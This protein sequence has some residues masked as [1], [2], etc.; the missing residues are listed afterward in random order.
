MIN[1][2]K[3][4]K[5]LSDISKRDW[6]NK[7]LIDKKVLEIREIQDKIVQY[8]EKTKFLDNCKKCLH[9]C[10]ASFIP[11]LAFSLPEVVYYVSKTNPDITDKLN[12]A[13]FIKGKCC[14]LTNKGCVLNDNGKP[15]MCISYFCQF[16]YKKDTVS[17][18][19][20]LSSKFYELK[21]L[22]YEK[23]PRQKNIGG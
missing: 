17:F 2:K 7:E 20:V 10:C 5:L 16:P 12:S 13:V 3:I 1:R 6:D 22:M 9:V 15:N 4:L 19:N 18:K 14:L 21:E 11:K 8:M 23:K